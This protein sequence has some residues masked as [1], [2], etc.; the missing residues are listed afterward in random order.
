VLLV[1]VGVLGAVVGSFLNVVIYRVPRGESL[2]T[3][4]SHCPAC[5]APIAPY[6]NIP[7]LS[8]LLLRGRCR[9]C[10]ARISMRYPLVEILTALAFV[11][12]AWAVADDHPWAVP[13]YLYF[14]AIGVALAGIDLDVRRLPDV[15]VLPSYVVVAILLLVASTAE[16]DLWAMA[17]AV[18]GGAVLYAFYFS[19]MVVKPGA[20]GFGD[21]KLA[22]GLGGLLAWLGWGALVVG[23]FLAFLLGGVM[24]IVLMVVGRAGRKSQIPFGPYMIVGTYLGVL[25]G[26]QV[27]D[28][29]T[30]TLS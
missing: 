28:W 11:G 2:V 29:Y 27:W 23:G 25:W 18:A 14:A 24:G 21:V 4:A 12:M 10:Q 26:Q 9:R 16:H 30:G 22:G 20:M 19:L 5:D 8:W 17:R 13:A 15:I 3:P 7:V 6:D 1:F